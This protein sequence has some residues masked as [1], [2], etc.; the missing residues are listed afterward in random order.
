MSRPD[1]ALH[2][3]HVTPFFLFPEHQH[4]WDPNFDPL[5]G[6]Q[7]LT[8]SLA[9]RL[10]ANG[11]RQTVLTMGLPGAPRD[12]T[13]APNVEVHCRRFPVLP[14]R[15][16]LEGYFGLVLAF[17]TAA[18]AWARKHRKR[19]REDIDVVHVHCDGSGS[20]PWAGRTIARTVGAPLVMQIYSCRTLTQEPTTLMERILD[21]LSKRSEVATM[22]AADRLLT[23]T[24]KI[25]RRI[26]TELGIDADK[27]ERL[28]YL[29]HLDFKANDTPARRADLQFRFSI[30]ND[31]P[32]VAY[33]GRVAAEKG[34]DHFVAMAARL[35]VRHGCHFMVIGD[36]PELDTIR[37]LVQK[38]G[39]AS[40]FIFTGFL[41]PELVASAI[42]FASV[43]VVPSH[44]EELGLVILEFM[45]AGVPVVAHG[46]GAVDE[47]IVD[48]SNGL[49]VTP[50]DVPALS[51]AVTRVL[52]DHEL[53]NRLVRGAAATPDE[54]FSLDAAA[55]QARR[56]Y[57]SAQRR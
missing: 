31:R 41:A 34:V 56:I 22:R 25:K 49:I 7:L 27:I 51:E 29:T 50:F 28:A 6:M 52:T 5:G 12:I 46:V 13:A 45:L 1:R 53:R 37:A 23:L 42:S 21:P 57:E 26:S 48:G 55:Q 18:A 16:K 20:V 8:H 35:A 43:G 40:R 3:L 38:Q 54:K 39:L 47:L 44:Y 30:P 2:I 9:V 36:G 19:L 24:F 10:G 33:L 11:I 17:S 32:I 14:I 15:S 4:L